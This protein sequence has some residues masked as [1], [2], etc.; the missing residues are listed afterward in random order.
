[1]SDNTVREGRRTAARGSCDSASRSIT[2][3]RFVQ[4]VLATGLIAGLD[5]WRWPAFA[6]KTAGG[7]PLLSGNSF[8]LA[9][10]ETPVNFTGQRSVATAINGS[11]PGPILRWRE[12]DEVTI[13]V[14]NHLKVPTSIHWHGV[15]T[16]SEMDGV[17][18]LSFR[19]IGPGDTFVYRFPVRQH[20]TYWYHSHSR[21]QEQSGHYGALIIDPKGKD[22]IEYDREYVILLSDW[23]DEHPETIFSNL[24]QQDDYYDHHQRTIATFLSDARKQGLG[25]ALSDRMMWGSMNMTPTDILDVS[26]ATYTYLVNGRPPAANWT[27]LFQ[28][29][30]RVRLRF[31]NGSSMSIFDVRIP[32][33]PMNVVQADGN[34]VEPITVDE[35]RIS[36]AETYDV[37][38]RPKDATVF[39]IFAQNEDRTGFARATL[40]PRGGMTAP[41]PPMDPRPMLTM[42]DMGM[43]DMTGMQMGQTPEEKTGGSNKANGPPLKPRPAG[44]AGKRSRTIIEMPFPQP[45]PDTAGLP[46]PVTAAPPMPPKPRVLHEGPEV[47]N[48]A[49][50]PANR[51]AEAGNGLN[52]NGRRVLTYTDLRARYRGTDPRPAE[53]DIELHLTGNMQRFIWGFNGEK[54]S[55]AEPIRLRLGERVR[56]IIVNDT[57]MEHPVHLHG[58]WSELEN[59]FGEVRPYKHTINVKAGERL[60]YLVSADTPGRCAYHCHLLYHMEA[61]MF[62]TVIVS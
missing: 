22:S 56:F 21:F 43:G 47:D 24:K 59:G 20:G 50:M 35:F 2:R 12:G 45:G 16:P 23:T 58:L 26:G 57:M 36:T 61:G 55:G 14:T 17:P 41:I 3:R 29:R 9:I 54:F 32:G 48:V 39:T 44:P 6:V 7:P 30:E 5:P 8:N 53:R 10:A 4:G 46:A 60:S 42:A 40:A 25:A 52:H 31:I 27:A 19:G 33:L 38:V 18:G 51:L 15:R 28:P 1:M 37:I 34:D 49:M 62:R 13:S 11:V